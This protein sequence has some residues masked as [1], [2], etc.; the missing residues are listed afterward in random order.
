MNE[1]MS[2]AGI[3]KSLTEYWSPRVI[4][5]IADCYVKVAKLEGELVWHAHDEEAELFFVL[6]GNLRIEMESGAVDLGPGQVYVVPRG[7]RHNPV[8]DEECLVMLFERKS[9]LHTGN[10]VTG[11]TRTVEEQLRPY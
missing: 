8:A 2:P 7:V 11:K 5:E 3:A 9:T 4:A 6:E 10:E 1:A